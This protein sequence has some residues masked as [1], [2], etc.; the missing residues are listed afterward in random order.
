M[1]RLRRMFVSFMVLSLSLSFWVSPTQAT[2]N[3][4]PDFVL[5]GAR[6]SGEKTPHQTPSKSGEYIDSSAP[7]QIRSYNSWLGKTVGS[8]YTE[9]ITMKDT[10]FV[11]F[12]PENTNTKISG[13]RSIAWLSYGVYNTQTIYPAVG[14]PNFLNRDETRDYI[15]EVVISNKGLLEISLREYSARCP[16]SKFFLAGYSQGAAIVRLSVNELSSTDDADVIQRILGV[17]L[18]ADPLLSPKDKRLPVGSDSRWTDTKSTCGAVRLI[19]SFSLECAFSQK[20]LA[21]NLFIKSIQKFLP[22]VECV[23]YSGCENSLAVDVSLAKEAKLDSTSD[24]SKKTGIS[25]IVS[26]CYVGDAVCSLLGE[27]SKLAW[28]GIL[29]KDPGKIHSEEYKKPTTSS[30]IARWIEKRVPPKT[31]K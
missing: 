2:Q 5:V 9:L 23:T 26:V 15:G 24:I 29:I 18:I 8:L 4:C 12:N 31:T 30:A 25:H 21:G 27:R 3:V 10:P 16:N 22:L 6:G 14:V 1:R 19:A 17:I 7:S 11:P 28:A 13:K 20:S